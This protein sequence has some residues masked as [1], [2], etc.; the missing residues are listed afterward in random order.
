MRIVSLVPSS[1]GRG[2]ASF[3]RRPATVALNRDR[4]SRRPPRARSSEGVNPVCR[5]RRLRRALAELNRIRI[6]HLDTGDRHVQVITR[7]NPLQA[8]ILA[9]LDINTSTWDNAHIT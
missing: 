1:G 9:T 8:S 2:A 7:R 5:C 4:I 3:A 6:H